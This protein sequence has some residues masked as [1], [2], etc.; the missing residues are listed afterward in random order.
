MNAI[1]SEGS[2]P[3]FLKIHPFFR[4]PVPFWGL[5]RVVC[6]H[7][8]LWKCCAKRLKRPLASCCSVLALLRIR[9]SGGKNERRN[10]IAPLPVPTQRSLRQKFSQRKR[11]CP[12]RGRPFFRTTSSRKLLRKSHRCCCYCCCYQLCNIVVVVGDSI[13]QVGG[14]TFQ[15]TLPVF[16]PE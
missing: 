6:P 8:L 1:F 14:Y 11:Y 15:T 13:G 12:R 2:R 5:I 16:L 3:D 9:S 7:V 4:T 10:T